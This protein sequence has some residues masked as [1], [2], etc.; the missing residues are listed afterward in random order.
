MNQTPFAHALLDPT[1]PVPTGWVAHNGSDPRP[2]FNV[3]RNNV[4]VS[5]VQA[6]RDSFPAL[7][8]EAGDAAFGQWAHDYVRTHPPRHP[9]LAF[10]GDAFP[11]HL[12]PRLSPQSRWL[13]DLARLEL[14]RIHAFHALDH[15]P[16]D[17]AALLA[18]SQQAGQLEQARIGL[19][20]G[21][22]VVRS[23][24]PVF[25]TWAR[26]QGT[27]AD[28]RR[29]PVAQSVLITREHWDVVV[30]LIDTGCATF[31]ESLGDGLPLGQA[32]EHATAADPAFDLVQTLAL[33][34]RQQCLRDVTL[35]T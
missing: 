28:D 33:L 14:A 30:I 25:D 6:L 16:M 29:E 5:L 19:V 31:I 8:A 4:V 3:Y 1:A 24:G 11:A 2:R 18:L 10:Y 22:T 12:A 17:G 7:A 27:V 32:Q 9:M 35:P 21:V 26:H 23:H 15:P 13:H 34:I 20:P